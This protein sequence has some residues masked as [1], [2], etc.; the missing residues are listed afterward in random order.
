M[1]LPHRSQGN[2]YLTPIPTPIPNSVPDPDVR[3]LG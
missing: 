1:M 2:L 3:S